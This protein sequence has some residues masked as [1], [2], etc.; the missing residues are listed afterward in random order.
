M[1]PTG[2]LGLDLPLVATLG[3]LVA[4]F[5]LFVALW[6]GIPHVASQFVDWEARAAEASGQC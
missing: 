1:S 6:L 3:L 2:P 4:A 5:A